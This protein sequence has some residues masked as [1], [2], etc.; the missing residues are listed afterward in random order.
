MEAQSSDDD[1][2]SHNGDQ[3][4][5]VE[6]DHGSDTGISMRRVAHPELESMGLE[7]TKQ[8]INNTK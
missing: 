4:A 3:C 7:L 1:Q 6:E 2:P 5:Q 8:H